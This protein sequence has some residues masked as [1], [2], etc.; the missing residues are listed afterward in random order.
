ML[1]L[2]KKEETTN[3]PNLSM[4]ILFAKGTLYWICFLIFLS[5][6]KKNQEVRPAL[7]AKTI[8]MQAGS[9]PIGNSSSLWW[10][11]SIHQK[12]MPFTNPHNY[13]HN[14][15]EVSMW[16]RPQLASE[17]G[18]V[19][20]VKIESGGLVASSNIRM[21]PVSLP[22]PQNATPSSHTK[23]AGET[24]R[25]EI[26]LREEHIQVQH[27]HNISEQPW[28]T[29]SLHSELA[30]WTSNNASGSDVQSITGPSLN[31]ISTN[32]YLE[33]RVAPWLPS[34]PKA[35]G[36]PTIPPLRAPSTP[37]EDSLA[38][39]CT[40]QTTSAILLNPPPNPL[41]P[42]APKKQDTLQPHPYPTSVKSPLPLA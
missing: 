14:G 1:D 12:E 23:S 29:S 15:Q 30:C 25:K 33:Q 37:G 17:R 31:T 11:I 24:D 32:K 34:H 21:R 10:P 2:E 4:T 26:S 8:N 6:S 35:A 13:V 42:V 19:Q 40:A 20:V 7:Q 16:T 27:L 22:C 9:E 36:N 28:A 38:L 5:P 18:V 41:F 39:A 3:C